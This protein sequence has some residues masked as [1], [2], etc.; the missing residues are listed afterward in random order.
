MLVIGGGAIGV[1]MATI[2]A[3]FGCSVTL[4]ECEEQLLP[5]EDADVSQEVKK[6]L[7]KQSVEVLTSCMDALNSTDKYEKV[8]IV[9][10][11]SPA[12][13]LGLDKISVK[14][15]ARVF[16]ETNEFCQTNIEIFMLSVTLLA[17]VC[18]PVPLKMKAA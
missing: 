9:T 16:V 11:R 14:T 10:G 2:F 6:N 15:A 4:A 7:S 5:N 12:N 3:G 13:D 18:L 8:L 17:K 1:E